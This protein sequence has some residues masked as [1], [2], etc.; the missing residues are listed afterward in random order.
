MNNDWYYISV[1]D[2]DDLSDKGWLDV[3]EHIACTPLNL[4]MFDDLD[5]AIEFKTKL[6]EK[7]ADHGYEFNIERL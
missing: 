5:A 7:Y 6:K 3:F 4:K 1:W 2:H